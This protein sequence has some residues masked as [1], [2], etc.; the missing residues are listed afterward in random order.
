MGGA[1]QRYARP[2]ELDAFAVIT[3]QK[4][5]ACENGDKIRENENGRSK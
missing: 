4:R 5:N 1:F 2:Y 3:L